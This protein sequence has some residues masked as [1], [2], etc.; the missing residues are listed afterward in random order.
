MDFAHKIIIAWLHNTQLERV[1]K[2][3]KRGRPLSSIETETLKQNWV[4]TFR[5]WLCDPSNSSTKAEREDIESELEIRKE[6]PPVNLVEDA[7]NA[8]ARAGVER[9]RADPTQF[10]QA[11]RD[12]WEE[13]VE[14]LRG[15]EK[16]TPN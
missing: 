13:I 1:E 2:Y 7:L 9:L 5:K 16:A 15:L 3:V 12:I 11:N 14:F 4:V 8:S 10:E 6:T